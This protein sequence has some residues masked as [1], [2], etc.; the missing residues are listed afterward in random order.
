MN[1]SYSSNSENVSVP[2]SNGQNSID[3]MSLWN[4]EQRAGQPM[5][6]CAVC[7]RLEEEL[8]QLLPKVRVQRLGHI[9][10]KLKRSRGQGLR[11]KGL[12]QCAHSASCK[13][14]SGITKSIS[15]SLLQ[16]STHMGP[17]HHPPT[18]GALSPLHVQ[19]AGVIVIHGCKE[20]PEPEQVQ[21]L[22]PAGASGQIQILKYFS[23]WV[24]DGGLRSPA[25]GSQV[26][27]AWELKV[28]GRLTEEQCDLKRGASKLWQ[29]FT[30]KQLC[31]PR[32]FNKC[33]ELS[34]LSAARIFVSVCK[35]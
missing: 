10:V 21:G 17:L 22:G 1:N 4:P 20:S 30:S 19:E 15:I 11:P 8:R 16:A 6:P 2:D 12:G 32:S 24:K 9:P 31:L 33:R 7:P 34:S 23:C 3:S 26:S 18:L 29:G 28:L 25:V 13:W 14:E 27:G 5:C 35:T